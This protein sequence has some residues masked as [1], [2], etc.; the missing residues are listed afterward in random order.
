ME[1]LNAQEMSDTLSLQEAS[2]GR[3]G[4]LWQQKK[5]ISNHL[6]V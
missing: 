2:R 6:S 3:G 1:I 5:V 4:I